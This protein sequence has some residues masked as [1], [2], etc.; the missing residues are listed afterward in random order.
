M[1][2]R[3]PA[4]ARPAHRGRVRGHRGVSPG[5]AAP[6]RPDDRRR[7]D[8]ARARPGDR[9]SPRAAMTRNRIRDLPMPRNILLLS[10]LAAMLAFVPRCL[11]VQSQA[12]AQTRPLEPA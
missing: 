10:L 5:G 11:A 3:T 9:L 7:A 4:L 1:S 2:R 12:P 8:H 6:A